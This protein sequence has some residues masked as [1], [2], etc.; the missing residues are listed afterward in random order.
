MHER[1][2]RH[3]TTSLTQGNSRPTP[4]ATLFPMDNDRTITGRFLDLPG[5]GRTWVYEAGTSHQGK[6]P[7][8]VLVHGSPGASICSWMPTMQLLARDFHVVAMDIRGHG[9]GIRPA[10]GFEAEPFSLEACADDLAAALGELRI[11]RAIIAAYSI[12]GPIAQLFWKHHPQMT[13][14][15]VFI[16][17]A[18][19]LTP[20][21]PH[22]FAS[23]FRHGGATDRGAHPEAPMPS[24]PGIPTR[25]SEVV[26][27][28][29]LAALQADAALADFD[30]SVWLSS[31]NVPTSVV[32]T[33]H[34]RSVAPETQRALARAL[35]THDIREV[36]SRLGHLSLPLGNPTMLQSTVDA[37]HAMAD[38]HGPTP[39]PGKGLN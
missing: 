36:P 19:H 17:T 33:T 28:D 31:V 10:R 21:I 3:L 6:V 24:P 22:A 4:G 35:G 9:R 39:P 27:T 2:D 30:S 11:G 37:C 20:A 38:M 16:A 5:R 23:P 12:G 15:L 25:F 29:P 34:D 32:V 1:F 26:H 18:M 8:V 14:A 13:Q 7:T